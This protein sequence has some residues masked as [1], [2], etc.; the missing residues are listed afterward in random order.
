[1]AEDLPLHGGKLYAAACLIEKV[2][3]TRSAGRCRN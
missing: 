3:L 2:A 1:V